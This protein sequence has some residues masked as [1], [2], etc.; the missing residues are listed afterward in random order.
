MGWKAEVLVLRGVEIEAPW[1]C[2]F[3]RPC[4][5]S[6]MAVASILRMYS[7]HS[8]VKKVDLWA[9]LYAIGPRL[10]SP[11]WDDCYGSTI[12]LSEP[13]VLRWVEQQRQQQQQ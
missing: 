11:P 9:H 5:G 7:M 1:F 13:G 4:K 10:S 8:P 12:V 2:T 3:C 6:Y